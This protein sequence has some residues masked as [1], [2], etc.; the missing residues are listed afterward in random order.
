MANSQR[1]AKTD[2]RNYWRDGHHQLRHLKVR[3]Q[4]VELVLASPPSSEFSQESESTVEVQGGID[5]KFS[6]VDHTRRILRGFQFSMQLAVTKVN[7]CQINHFVTVR[8]F[9][10]GLLMEEFPH[11]SHFLVFR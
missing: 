11:L 2:Y 9:I 7:V 3:D 4:Q 10:L 6:T 8:Y 1:L 5:S